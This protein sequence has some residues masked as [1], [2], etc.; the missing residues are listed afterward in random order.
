MAVLKLSVNDH[1]AMHWHDDAGE[2][3]RGGQ[4]RVPTIIYG[5][6]VHSEFDME[7]HIGRCRH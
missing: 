1:C 5:A 3:G 7:Q 6:V 4:W 2:G